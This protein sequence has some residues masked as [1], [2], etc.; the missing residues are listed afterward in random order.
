MYGAEFGTL[1]ARA[2]GALWDVRAG[3]VLAQISLGPGWPRGW[4]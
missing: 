2:A 3:L 4:G 1:A